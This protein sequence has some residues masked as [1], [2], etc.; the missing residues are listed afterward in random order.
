VMFLDFAGA[1]FAVL[2]LMLAKIPTTHDASAEN[3][4][5]FANL[6]D[7]WKILTLRRGL[8]TLIVGVGIGM[9]IFAP[10]GTL[11]PLMVF[12]HFSGDGYMASMTEAS[13]GLGMLVGSV[14]LLAWGGGKRLVRLV[15]VS[16][17]LVGLVT[18]ACG[19]LTSDMFV[20]F[21][22]L[23]AVMAIAFAGFNGPFITIIQ[24]NVPEE[25]LGRA[26]G[27]ITAMT[28]IASPV[29]IAFGGMLAEAIGIADFF[30]VDGVLFALLAAIV[31]GFKR[32][33][34]LDI[35]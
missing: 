26:L 27:L 15:S 4:N 33:R 5:I 28:G 6:R 2:G 10:L 3:Q 9:V 18:A 22:V 14:I 12:D 13:F 8:I 34:D 25:K 20:G 30:L 35:A 11:F 17:F 21:V 1:I 29:G 32:V 16:V 23:C 24:K 31:Y 19:L 7:G